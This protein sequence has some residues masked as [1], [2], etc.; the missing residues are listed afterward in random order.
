MVGF[1]VSIVL[2]ALSMGIGGI[3]NANNIGFIVRAISVVAFPTI[4]Y[5]CWSVMQR[6]KSVN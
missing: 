2:V 5:L 4:S 6:T 1:A 3:A